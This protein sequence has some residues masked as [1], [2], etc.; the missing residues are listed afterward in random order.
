MR[1]SWCHLLQ[2]RAA[3]KSKELKELTADS[4]G[5]YGLSSGMHATLLRGSLQSPF[6]GA[7]Y[8]LTRLSKLTRAE[9]GLLVCRDWEVRIRS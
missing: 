8:H 2:R 5:L 3:L 9:E 4:Y 1:F 7:A 6:T